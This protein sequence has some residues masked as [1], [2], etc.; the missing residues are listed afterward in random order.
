MAPET[1]AGA[2]SNG[3]TPGSEPG[4]RGSNPCAPSTSESVAPTV[5]QRA[6]TPRAEGSIPSRLATHTHGARILGAETGEG[7]AALSGAAA[8]V[9]DRVLSGLVKFYGPSAVARR[10]YLRALAED[11]GARIAT[12]PGVV[13]FEQRAHMVGVELGMRLASEQAR[14]RA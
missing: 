11:V 10:Q 3:R 13:G 9:R 14:S 8:P 7:A 6:P 1:F 5:E 2:S 4:D 12:V